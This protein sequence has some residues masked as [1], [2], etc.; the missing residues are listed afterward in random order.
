MGKNALG[1]TFYLGTKVQFYFVM[2]SMAEAKY[3]RNKICGSNQLCYPNNMV[4][5]NFISGASKIEY[6]YKDIL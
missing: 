4:E 1:Q 5:K 2:L 6:S 3:C